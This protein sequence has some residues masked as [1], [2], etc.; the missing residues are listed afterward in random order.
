MVEVTWG[1]TFSDLSRVITSNDINRIDRA[2]VAND[3]GQLF[4]GKTESGQKWAYIHSALKAD[5]TF[6]ACPELDTEPQMG[7]YGSA[8]VSNGSGVF[9]TKP[10]LQ[11]SH[12]ARPYAAFLIAGDSKYA[13]YPVDFDITLT[14]A[15]GSTVINV[16]G[17]TERVYTTSF[18]PIPDVTAVKIEIIKWSKP[19]TIVKI[20]QFSGAFIEVYK[21]DDIVELSILE[22]SNSDTGIVPIGN[23]SANELDLTLLNTDRRFS[24][25]N[26]DSVYVNVLRSGRKIRV[27]LG[28][29]LPVGSADQSGDVDGYIVETVA[30]E[31]IGY[32]PYGI[33][34]SKDWISSYDSQVTT[35]T[36][37][38]V[39][40]QLGQIDFL[41]SLNYTDTVEAI[42]NE[43]LTEAKNE[44]PALQWV[45]SDD[46]AAI[47]WDNIAFENKNY[48]EILKDIAEATLSYTYVN[49]NGVLVV[50]SRLVVDTDGLEEYKKIGMDIYFNFQSEPKI[51]ELVNTVRV[52]FVDYIEGAPDTSIYSSGEV[53]EI[54]AGATELALYINWSNKPIVVS[55]AVVALA[56]ETGA[57]VLTSVDAY[58]NGANITVTG[59]PGDTFKVTATGTPYTLE[60]NTKTTANNPESVE[61][62]G[63]R[64][65]ELTGN[66]LIKSADQARE[67]A[68]ELIQFYGELRDDGNF[69]WHFS[70]LV[71]IGDTVEVVEFKSTTVETKTNFTIKRQTIKYAGYLEAQ[72]NLRREVT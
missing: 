23:V 12:V 69:T 59:N 22:E 19:N 42:V 33:Y 37:Y 52:G 61:I 66:Q 30:G 6:F 57:A 32:M 39:A 36:A 18:T 10:Y 49:K 63:V 64:E 56:E 34:W 68:D 54:P 45:V 44:I 27:W 7:W 29:V 50:G 20:I 24:H 41:K 13:E 11:F 53:F 17:N 16:V 31:K 1:D 9:S 71:S 26:T 47:A 67:L 62:F 65:Y 40:Y 60:E 48:L 58:A 21:A 8:L 55:T 46:T 2:G 25:G 28:F 4:N 3:V 70:T 72:T 5:G 43:V 14:H 38:D 35:T 15:A 51:D